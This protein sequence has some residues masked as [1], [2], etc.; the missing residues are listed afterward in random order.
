MTTPKNVVITGSTRGIGLG[1]AREFLVRGQNVVISS[2]S[3]AAVD[4]VL[5]ELKQTADSGKASVIGMPCDVGQYERVQELWNFAKGKFGQVDIWINNAGL[6]NDKMPIARLPF[7]QFDTV[8]HTNLLGA[9]NGCKVALEGMRKQTHGFIYNFEG[10]G[11]NGLQNPGLSAY[12][13]TK[14]AI[15][16]FT[17]CLIRETKN[18]NV[19]VGYMSPGIVLTELALGD[20]D[21]MPPQARESVKKVYNILADRVETVT[22]YLAEG[23][24]ANK[25]HG[26]RVNWLTPSKSTWR[27]LKSRFVKRDLMD[28]WEAEAA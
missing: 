1:L 13:A 14:F 16:Y 25:R 27:F 3:Q 11:S 2:R 20:I 10:F 21:Q 18:E 6:S 17:K 8:V 28:K 26:G 23:V 4:K 9:F 24:L 19:I 5:R 22:P 7:K 15:T 12:G